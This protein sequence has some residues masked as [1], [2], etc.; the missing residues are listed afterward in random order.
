MPTGS[1]RS[2]A[3]RLFR[4]AIVLVL[5]ISA[6]AVSADAALSLR[7]SGLDPDAGALGHRRSG[8]SGAGCRSPRS[9]RRCRAPCWS[10]RM[11]AS[12]RHHGVDFEELRAAIEDADD[13]SRDARRLDHRAADREEPVPLAG[14]LVVRKALEFPLALWIDLVL[15][16]RRVMEIYLNIAEWGPNGEFGA[17]AGARHAFGKSARDLTRARGG[18]A[19]RHPAQSGAPQRRAPGCRRAPAGRD[20]PGAGAPDR[21]SVADCLR[22]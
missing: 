22:R 18:A 19:R 8:S 1:P 9:R 20:L 2:L 14:P 3:F 16:K 12:A 4:A 10:P 15:G 13:L 21:A 17:E 11:R 5:A 7:R 6:A